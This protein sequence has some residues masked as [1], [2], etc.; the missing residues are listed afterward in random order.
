M[1][2][3]L[4]FFLLLVIYIANYS[5]SCLPDG[6]TFSSQIQI[7]SFQVNYPGCTEIEGTVLISG[8]SITNLEGL[9]NIVSIGGS[10]SID[11]CNSLTNIT[12]LSNLVSIGGGL[13]VSGNPYLTSLQGLENITHLAGLTFSYNNSL[14]DF[15]GLNNLDTIDNVFSLQ[16][17]GL[18][19]FTGLEN[20]KYIGGVFDLFWN[21]DL[22]SFTGMENL[23]YIGGEYF[24][25]ETCGDLTDISSL[26]N[27]QTIAGDIHI[28]ETSLTSLD[29]LD[30][31][32]PGSI[33]NLSIYKNGN[34]ETCNVAAICEYLVS[35][36]GKVIIYGNAEGCND[37]S[38]I[39]QSCGNTMSCLPY[40]DYY[41]DTQQKIDSF[42]SNYPGCSNLSGNV[43]IMNYYIDNLAG[44]LPIKSVSG[45]L[46]IFK[47]ADLTSLNGLDSLASVGN[48][49]YLGGYDLW[50]YYQK[51][52]FNLTDISALMN[53]QHIGYELYIKYNPKLSNLNGLDSVK[54]N[55]D[56][57]IEIASNENLSFCSVKSLCDCLTGNC[58]TDIYWNSTGCNSVE[59]V[60]QACLVSAE[61]MVFDEAGFF[62]NPAST[63][64]ILNATPTTWICISNLNG[65]MITSSEPGEKYINLEDTSNGLYIVT[66]LDGNKEVI[67]EKLVVR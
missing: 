46:I 22:V 31:I 35:P 2:K 29:G 24:W 57:Y 59:E 33:G 19:N 47:T 48:T 34:L 56:N 49:F 38:V 64:I 61:E 28:F 52:N 4:L 23:E 20:L 60:E 67:R 41:F 66:I 25:I 54:F 18:L 10:L 44:L 43:T 53:L 17:T 30:N 40:G 8:E 32:D 21:M 50:P 7:D 36:N 51:G 12:G 15:T 6:I 62:P 3:H 26:S 27:L 45:D 16:N 55:G 11:Y 9:N 1:K 5:Q 13:G 39:A 42:Q 37:P 63:Y 14:T 58:Y 65:Q